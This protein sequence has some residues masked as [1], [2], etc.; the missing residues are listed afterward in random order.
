MFDRSRVHMDTNNIA[1]RV[2]LAWTFLN[3]TVLR[4]GYGSGFSNFNRTGTSYLAYNA[5]MFVLASAA[6][7]PGTP[8]FLNAQQGFPADFT[9]PDKFDPRKSTV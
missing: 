1:L 5:P 4:A 7:T 8:G 6:Q 2:G 3:K 9:S